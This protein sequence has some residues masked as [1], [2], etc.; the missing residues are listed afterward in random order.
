MTLSAALASLNA[1]LKRSAVKSVFEVRD[2]WID[3]AY[4][5][6]FTKSGVR[7]YLVGRGLVLDEEGGQ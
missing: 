7:R 3:G 1:T 6:T 2:L 4:V 5:G